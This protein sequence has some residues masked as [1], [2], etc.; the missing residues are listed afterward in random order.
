MTFGKMDDPVEASFEA[1]QPD[2]TNLGER[3]SNLA[4]SLTGIKFVP[5]KLFQILR[6]QFAPWVK[7]SKDRVSIYRSTLRIAAHGIRN[8]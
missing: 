3:L 4:L 6:D 7:V 2:S 1:W 8:K 5:A